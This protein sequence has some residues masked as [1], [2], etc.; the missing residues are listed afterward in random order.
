MK[1]EP[2]RFGIVGLKRGL[3]ALS[4]LEEE[5]V[6]ITAVCDNNPAKLAAA[7]ETIQ[8]ALAAGNI[9]SGKFLCGGVD[10]RWQTFFLPQW[11]NPPN[12]VSRR[13]LRDH[14]IGHLNFLGTQRFCY[15]FKIQLTCDRR[16]GHGKVFHITVH[17]HQQRFVDLI[18]IQT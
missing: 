14:R 12:Q 13:T 17:C 3:C 2:V 6:L 8:S 16:N 15:F 4:L 11:A 10:N 18:R 9:N 7:K 1:K 5:S